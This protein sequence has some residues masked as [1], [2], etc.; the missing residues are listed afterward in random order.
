MKK[1]IGSYKQYKLLWSFVI[2]LIV[3]S[4][5]WRKLDFKIDTKIVFKSPEIILERF[6]VSTIK[7]LA[8]KK[9]LCKNTMKYVRIAVKKDKLK[10]MH[11]SI[12]ILIINIYWCV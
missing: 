9:L 11:L 3:Y 4:I 1:H 12:L 8:V 2:A 10:K 6:T 5:N 7:R